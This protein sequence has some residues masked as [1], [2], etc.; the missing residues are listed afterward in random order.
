[1]HLSYR[2]INILKKEINRLRVKAELLDISNFAERREFQ[3]IMSRLRFIQNTMSTKKIEISPTGSC[4][5]IRFQ[6]RL[7]SPSP[8]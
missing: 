8:F 7:H 5:V 1:M 2:E 3:T 4:N 6:P